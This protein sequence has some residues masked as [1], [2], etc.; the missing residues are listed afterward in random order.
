VSLTLTQLGLLI[1]RDACVANL[2]T[3]LDRGGEV[4]VGVEIHIE[5]SDVV[6][7]TI[8]VHREAAATHPDTRL[9]IQADLRCPGRSRR[10]LCQQP[11]I[12]THSCASGHPTLDLEDCL[13]HT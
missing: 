1:D 13:A 12:G 9:A 11:T 4:G 5:Q 3:V 6:G 10:H 8:E 2:A 7:D